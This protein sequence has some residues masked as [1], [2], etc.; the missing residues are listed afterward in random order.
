MKYKSTQRIVRP[1]TDPKQYYNFEIKRELRVGPQ[2][3][4]KSRV[5]GRVLG[6][7]VSWRM[8]TME[9]TLGHLGDH[10]DRLLRVRSMWHQ[11]HQS[12]N[13]KSHW[14]PVNSGAQNDPA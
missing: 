13:V 12:V 9:I 2:G 7:R 11:G 8:A 14:N 10:P 6:P 4:T 5:H 1:K 3:G